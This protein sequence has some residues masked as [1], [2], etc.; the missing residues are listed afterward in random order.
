M[1][2][3]FIKLIKSNSKFFLT[4]KIDIGMVMNIFITRISFQKLHL[5]I[6]KKKTVK[7]PISLVSP[8]RSHWKKITPFTSPSNLFSCYPD[9]RVTCQ[10]Y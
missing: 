10:S 3:D 1:C 8:L 9:L 6:K 4:F 5:E 2:C 7:H